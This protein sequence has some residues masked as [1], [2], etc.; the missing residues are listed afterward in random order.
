M[1][2]QDPKIN[3]STIAAI[4]TL[5]QKGGPPERLW[6]AV[7]E[8]ALLDFQENGIWVSE[9]GRKQ[10]KYELLSHLFRIDRAP[11]PAFVRQRL[12]WTI[13]NLFKSGRAFP[14]PETLFPDISEEIE[15]YSFEDRYILPIKIKAYKPKEKT[16]A[17]ERKFLKLRTWKPGIMTKKILRTKN[18]TTE[19][20]ETDN[21]LLKQSRTNKY[22][23]IQNREANMRK[24]DLQE[25][26]EKLRENLLRELPPIF[27]RKEVEKLLPGVI[28]RRTLENLDSMGK[29]PNGIGNGKKILYTREEFVDWLI[30]YLQKKNQVVNKW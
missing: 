15:S 29:G 22:Q 5:L 12:I 21:T 24:V 23:K 4:S 25:L 27:A 3:F 9:E 19:I 18:E 10:L 11:S 13:Q 1:K 6:D 7:T 28:S 2:R 30:N 17:L 8:L 26:L 20:L 16:L 14:R